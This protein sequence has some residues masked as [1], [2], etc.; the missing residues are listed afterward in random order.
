MIN[1]SLRHLIFFF[2]QNAFHTSQWGHF[3]SLK[4]MWTN[5]I[6]F[7]WEKLHGKTEYTFFICFLFFV[8]LSW[9]FICFYLFSGT[10]N[11]IQGLYLCTKSPDFLKF[12]FE[13]GIAKLLRSSLKLLWLTLNLPQPWVARIT[14]MCHSVWQIWLW[15]FIIFHI[16]GYNS[17]YYSSYNYS[18]QSWIHPSNEVAIQIFK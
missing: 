7:I 12:Y 4:D 1:K 10:R 11:W 9:L 14:G 2:P 16:L 18:E 5:F 15:L 8:V 13:I 6:S 17:T 3:R